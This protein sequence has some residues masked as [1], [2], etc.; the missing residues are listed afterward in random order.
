M[1]RL[2]CMIAWA[3][4]AVVMLPIAS[5]TAHG[6]KISLPDA[7]VTEDN[8][9]E[10]KTERIEPAE[11]AVIERYAKLLRSRPQ[12]GTA[13]D[14]FYEF[15]SRQGSLANYCRGLEQEAAKSS[16]G[17]LFHLL[18]LLQLRN[19]LNEAAIESLKRSQSL[20]PSD[21]AVSV[22]LSL[23]LAQ[24]KQYEA[25]LESLK[26][27]AEG[28]PTAPLALEIIKQ[29]GPLSRRLHSQMAAEVLVSL[30]SQFSGNAQVIEKLA[31]SLAGL[32]PEQAKALYVSL[33]EITREPQRRIEFQMELARLTKRLGQPELALS[34]LEALVGRV[35]PG[36]WIHA[37]LLQQIEQWTQEL[38]GADGLIERYESALIARPDNIAVMLRMARLL[39]NAE[40]LEEALALLEKTHRLVPTQ[41]EPLIQLVDLLESAQ[42]VDEA[43]SVCEKLMELEPAN[44]DYI[45]RTGQ[46][47][48]KASLKSLPERQSQVV[49]VWRRMLIGYE[50]D[51]ARRVQ[52]A[53]L[54]SD[55]GMQD[56][57]VGEFR[58]A[59]KIAG[60][61]VEFHE[62]FAD[63]LLRVGRSD[64]ARDVLLDAVERTVESAGSLA[65]GIAGDD[66]QVLVRASEWL[67]QRGFKKEAISTLEKA[68]ATQPQFSDLMKLVQMLTVDGRDAQALTVLAKAN[69]LATTPKEWSAV[70]DE[71]IAIFRREVA[72]TGR[73]EALK[74]TLSETALPAIAE[75]EQ[76]AVMQAALKLPREAAETVRGVVAR[77][78]SSLRHWLLGA[79][80]ERDAGLSFAEIES[81]RK[82]GEL[83]TRNQAEYLQRVAT[84]QLQLN[85]IDE[86]L[87]TLD[88]IVKLPTANLVH[89]QMAWTFCLQAKRPERAID[90]MRKA[91]AAF[92]NDRGAWLTLSQRLTAPADRAEAISATWRALEL[93]SEEAQ[94]KEVVDQLLQI[95]GGKSDLSELID[96][97]EQFGIA[98][99]RADDTDKWSAWVLRASD[100]REASVRLVASVLDRAN[101]PKELLE[102]AVQLGMKYEEF[103]K[104]LALQ[105]RL[106]RLSPS[107]R[108]QLLAGELM[109]LADDWQG[110]RMAWSSV[111][112]EPLNVAVVAFFAKELIVRGRLQ[113]VVE[114]AE[115][116]V[117]EQSAAWELLALGIQAIV[118]T[119]QIS[120]A[121]RLAEMLLVLKR[122][123]DLPAAQLV[124]ADEL[125]S[126]GASNLS[127][128]TNGSSTN[129]TVANGRD[130]LAW[131]EHASGWQ[132]R[133][134]E[135]DINRAGYRTT[136]SN[137]RSSQAAA[138]RHLAIQ[139]G[140]A[141]RTASKELPAIEYFGDAR[142]LAVLAKFGKVNQRESNQFQAWTEYVDA[143]ITSKSV[144]QL[145]EC[146]L[147][148]EPLRSRSVSVDSA[149]VVEVRKDPMLERFTEVLDGLVELSQVE[150]LELAIS[151]VV[152]RRH[153]QYQMA[154]RLQ[155]LVPNL[156]NEELVRL[157]NLVELG[158]ERGIRLTSAWVLTL[159][160]ELERAGRVDDAQRVLAKMLSE[161]SA[162]AGLADIEKLAMAALQ[163]NSLGQSVRWAN[164]RVLL[165]AFE[166]ELD[167]G[168]VSN[169]LQAALRAFVDPRGTTAGDYYDFLNS[170]VQVQAAYVS[171]MEPDAVV[172]DS[173]LNTPRRGLLNAVKNG[174]TVQVYLDRSSVFSSSLKLVLSILQEESR[175]NL[176]A[177]IAPKDRDLQL[178]GSLSVAERVVRWTCMSS[179]HA[180]SGQ[181]EEAL[182][183]LQ[184]AK[185]QAVAPE[186]LALQEVR[187]L[188]GLGRF[189]EA[190]GRL[191][192]TLPANESIL[193]EVELWKMELAIGN[194][195][196]QEAQRAAEVLAKL[197]LEMHDSREVATVLSRNRQR[198]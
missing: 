129:G 126:A 182:P 101:A 169:E 106:I 191:E 17:R 118:E 65:N 43:A 190:V 162:A 39:S 82:L 62:R 117:R 151:D 144:D 124:D 94:Q 112:R 18:G 179:V 146:V 5:R 123:H 192:K 49:G 19:D 77:D 37:S 148:M 78:S 7:S 163:I 74:R 9:N 184:L 122:P 155:Q 98:E 114:L 195:D 185:E 38:H 10:E 149:G 189:E 33:I 178:G 71:G 197:P 29:V 73:V 147:V 107:A 139:R 58:A 130:R 2:L 172:V 108:N 102:A 167:S 93:S 32:D 174:A 53:E 40:R 60:G 196:E 48:L 22:H 153:L 16:D 85:K 21:V 140:A 25:S 44:S 134:N 6:Q 46:L 91:T 180:A 113:A 95:Y 76:L 170:M 115:L 51:A 127:T 69:E 56:A 193:R 55:A 24:N 143:A 160:I 176:L 168:K 156:A 159:A 104:A 84:I 79:R 137:P 133:L 70:W 150:A 50:Q 47:L 125:D 3:M 116:A 166:L 72:L 81:L 13:L 99:D 75:L 111:I 64:E 11:Q 59:L 173:R 103:D 80:M 27:A 36:S 171:R 164:E 45:V 61:Q 68:C 109:A 158:E 165:R 26:A 23:A 86:A 132:A 92:A 119:Q 42:R 34:E 157:E 120:K 128:L 35:K 161:A 131:L 88:A 52:L 183:F 30:A 154:G 110:A 175:V 15:H 83:D 41:A 177:A 145:W 87:E 97:L 100:Q 57:A 28:K 63:Y 138:A 194:G 198:K 181:L 186:L 8:S 136:Q 20:S 66:R 152:S 187:V 54:F 89:Y 188:V 142:A 1:V 96:R 14:K 12:A 31:P 135:V 105:K 90:Y 121:E 141:I 67:S 4:V